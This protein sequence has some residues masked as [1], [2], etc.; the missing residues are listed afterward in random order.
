MKIKR[1]Y[2]CDRKPCGDRCSYPE[3]RHTLDKNH[4]LNPPNKRKFE[5]IF[6]DDNE[7][8]YFEIEE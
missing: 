3:C 1:A 7:Q 5:L 6:A 8:R 4:A 2:L